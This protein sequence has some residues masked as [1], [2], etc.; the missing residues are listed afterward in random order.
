M[1]FAECTYCSKRNRRAKLLKCLHS[2]CVGCLPKHMTMLNEVV[3]PTCGKL[4]PSSGEGKHQLLALPNSYIGASQ[5]RAATVEVPE[6][7]QDVLYCDECFDDE[8]AV[9]KCLDCKAV[10][11]DFHTQGHSRSRSTH[12]HT[13]QAIGEADGLNSETEPAVRRMHCI[14][15]P[16]GNLE[17]FCTSCKEFFCE[18]CLIRG[19][20]CKGSSNLS[21]S[22]L[23]V[24][25]AAEQLRSNIHQSMA[26]S[27]SSDK[28]SVFSKA[29]DNLK[30]AICHLHDRTEAVSE[31]IAEYFADVAK[32]VK[33]REAE[34]LEKLDSL[35]SAKLVPLEQQKVCLEKS[36]SSQET[37][38]MLLER[39][40]DD[41]DLICMSGWLQE[42]AIPLQHSAKKDIKPC[43]VSKLEFQQVRSEKLTAAVACVGSVLD[44][45][46]VDVERSILECQSWVRTG[47][48]MACYLK[49]FSK[50]GHPV[51]A[52]NVS[53][54]P[55][56]VEVMSPDNEAMSCKINLSNKDDD[57][58][59]AECLLA[60][61]G[62]YQVMARYCGQ[63][64]SGS[65]ANV[66][67][68]A[69]AFR[70]QACRCIKFSNENMTAAREVS[71]CYSKFHY[72]CGCEVYSK[73][74]IDIG[75]RIESVR[76]NCDILVGMCNSLESDK[77]TV[78]WHGTYCQSG[79]T[80]RGTFLGQPWEA[81]DVIRLSLDCDRHTL[82]GRHE[83]EGVTGK[84]QTLRSVAGGCYLSV[85]LDMLDKVTIL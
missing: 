55:L 11:C 54:M 79:K 25:E 5:H 32:L 34:M 43:L 26:E 53:I 23:S 65:P 71:Y 63:H 51:K 46:C 68:S 76:R 12:N 61:S 72:V 62:K 21:H 20:R 6:K 41:Y 37:V 36:L 74:T 83:R 66:M 42:A 50:D 14:I 39:C 40:D 58:L 31:D 19:G 67:V 1:P 81:G 45:S 60:T 73:G 33:S 8:K 64:L 78:G 27:F 15:H 29:I 38:S 44:A 85:H 28:E 52:E 49:A 7:R 47:Q 75:I 59:L 13:V 17:K 80:W 77:D 10:L 70:P 56:A 82:T 22:L 69:C 16:D 57:L 30:A 4:T 84:T 9:S 35:R 3:C 48:Q 18:Q 24:H 2:M